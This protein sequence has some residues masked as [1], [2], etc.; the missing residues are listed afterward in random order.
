MQALV[1]RSPK[2]T[3]PQAIVAAVRAQGVLVTRAGEDAVRL[4]PP[5]NCTFEEIDMAAAALAQAARDLL[6]SMPRGKRAASQ[7]ESVVP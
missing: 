2:R 1:V 7:R 5:L 3:P 6:S 4:L